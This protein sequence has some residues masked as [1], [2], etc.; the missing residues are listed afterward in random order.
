MAGAHWGWMV[1]VMVLCRGDREEI[2]IKMVHPSLGDKHLYLESVDTHNVDVDSLTPA[3]VLCTIS[4]NFKHSFSCISL[5]WK[6]HEN[7]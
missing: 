7:K 3:A 1:L 5:G 6:T 2:R 4:K